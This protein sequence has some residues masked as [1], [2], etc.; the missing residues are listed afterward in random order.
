MV[1]GRDGLIL[2]RDLIVEEMD[3]G[4]INKIGHA[5]SVEID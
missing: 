4:K 2:D 3:C 5:D 1:P